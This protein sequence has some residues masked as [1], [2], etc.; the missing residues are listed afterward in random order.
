[1]LEKERP[2]IHV[3]GEV[4]PRRRE[5]DEGRCHGGGRTGSEDGLAGDVRFRWRAEERGVATMLVARAGSD[6]ARRP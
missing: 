1:V 4:D 5:I 6:P 3:R 2:L